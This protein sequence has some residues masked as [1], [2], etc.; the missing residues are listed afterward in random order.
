MTP[1][2]SIRAFCTA[3]VGSPHLVKTCGGD[4]IIGSQ[5]TNN[6]ICHFFPFRLG[7]GRPSVK[8]IRQFCLLC[9]GG[10]PSLVKECTSKKCQVW[11]YRTGKNPNR[12]GIGDAN[13]LNNPSKRALTGIF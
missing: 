7:T 6:A 9:I 8:T 4:R 5:S 12:A 3:C 2:E 10:K 13:R 11:R 1:L